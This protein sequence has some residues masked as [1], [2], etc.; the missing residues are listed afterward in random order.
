MQHLYSHHK[1]KKLVT[2]LLILN[3][4]EL[5]SKYAENAYLTAKKFSWNTVAERTLYVYYHVLRR[6]EG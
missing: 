5:A 3:D 6:E 1:R 2:C 4:K